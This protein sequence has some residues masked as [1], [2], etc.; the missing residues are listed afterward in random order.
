MTPLRIC[1]ILAFF[2]LLTHSAVAAIG[3]CQD[4]FRKSVTSARAMSEQDLEVT[5]SLAHLAVQHELQNNSAV[6]TRISSDLADRYRHLYQLYGEL[7]VRE[8]RNAVDAFRNSQTEAKDLELRNE[9]EAQKELID[10]TRSIH[11]HKVVD[12]MIEFI[13]GTEVLTVRDGAI[14]IYDVI[15]EKRVVEVTD[16]QI[17]QN[18]NPVFNQNRSRVHIIN[19]DAFGTFVIGSKMMRWSQLPLG[20]IS[21]DWNARHLSKDGQLFVATG[22]YG[23]ELFLDL[24]D[25]EPVILRR[26]LPSPFVMSTGPGFDAKISESPDGRYIVISRERGSATLFDRS[27]KTSLDLSKMTFGD[28]LMGSILFAQDSRSFFFVNAISKVRRLDITTGQIQE[29]GEFPGS[30]IN[31]STDLIPTQ[32]HEW[33]VGQTGQWAGRRPVAMNLKTGKVVRPSMSRNDS[34]PNPWMAVHPQ[35]NIVYFIDPAPIGVRFAMDRIAKWDLDADTLKTIELPT[36]EA[37]Q[38]PLIHPESPRIFLPLPDEIGH[39]ELNLDYLENE[40]GN[41]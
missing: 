16:P 12:K 23:E 37:S 28:G 36:D 31:L 15:K 14:S 38:K 32:D 7:F 3:H 13:S 6:R 20:S 5:T 24:K 41:G 19:R 39:V 22:V 1:I 30:T 21:L 8:F 40:N 2:Q 29:I 35:K 25:P 4:L 10:S 9:S 26:T 33:W 27:T 11:H 18:P 17:R 34:G